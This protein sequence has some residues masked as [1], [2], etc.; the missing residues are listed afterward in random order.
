MSNSPIAGVLPVLH[1]PLLDDGRIDHQSLRREIDWAF[2]LGVNGVC[3]AMVSEILRLTVA[4][5]IELT[6]LMVEMTDGRGVVISSIGAESTEQAVWFGQQAEKAGCDAVMAIPPI[7]TALPDEALYRYFASLADAID[8]P[9]IVQDASSYVGRAIPVALYARLLDQYGQG[10]ILFKPEAAP[11]GPHLSALRDITAGRARIFDGSG[12]ILLVDAFRRGI[13]GTMPGCD[14]L[15]GIVALWRALEA[16]DEPSIYRLYFP[17][18][19]IVALQLQAGLDGFL[20]IAKYIMV[21][22][23]IFTSDRRREPFTWS[24]DKETAAEVDR[25]LVHLDDAL[26]TQPGG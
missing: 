25:L 3:A 18:C 7:S 4:E 20:A 15:N 23:G 2:D 14:L 6:Q 22:R 21:K 9:L 1:T 5:R 16:G 8:R 10:K 19:A 11:I 13:A 26:K 24:L 17:I 12:G